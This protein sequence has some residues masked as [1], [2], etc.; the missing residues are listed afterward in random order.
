MLR[1][2]TLQYA[3]LSCS[4]HLVHGPQFWSEHWFSSLANQVWSHNIW[5]CD[6]NCNILHFENSSISIC[7][8]WIWFNCI[9]N[10]NWHQFIADLDPYGPLT[11]PGVTLM[12][13]YFHS[14]YR[15][16]IIVAIFTTAPPLSLLTWGDP[17]FVQLEQN[18]NFI[19]SGNL[20]DCRTPSPGPPD[21]SPPQ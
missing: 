15:I 5:Q 1:L 20:H 6:V 8:K 19:Y 4:S 7:D 14:L 16:S 13:L 18:I 3:H 9:P 17:V 12:H 11:W 10:R 21:L 2:K